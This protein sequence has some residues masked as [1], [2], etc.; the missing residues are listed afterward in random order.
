MPVR[1]IAPSEFADNELPSGVAVVRSI[2]LCSASWRVGVLGAELTME[3]L[4]DLLLM[5]SP[6]F[7]A[8][9]RLFG[10]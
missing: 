7:A 8:A 6:S 10:G 4:R 9:R 5:E 1:S 2:C 3:V